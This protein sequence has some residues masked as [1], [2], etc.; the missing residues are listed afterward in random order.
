MNVIGYVRVSTEDQAENG[1]SVEGQQVALARWSVQTGHQLVRVEIDDGVSGE[2]PFA[3][4]RGGRAVMVALLSDD[5]D[6]VVAVSQ[7]RYYRDHIG[8]GM[9]HRAVTESGGLLFTVEQGDRPLCQTEG[10]QMV[11]GVAAMMHEHF[12]KSIAAHTTRVL[13]H[14][15]E[16]SL[17]SGTTPLTAMRVDDRGRP[18][19]TGNNLVPN[20]RMMTAAGLAH[21][22]QQE[23]MSLRKIG[24]R[25]KSDGYTPRDSGKDWMPTT[26]R[27]LIQQ[28]DGW[29]AL[30]PGFT[31]RK[32]RTTAGLE[33]L[34][35]AH[36]PP[37]DRAISSA[38]S[39]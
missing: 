14:R 34:L 21:T 8:W 18:S 31:A 20:P 26:V 3:A 10:E 32:R 37:R 5:V 19:P 27:S 15:R 12:R 1:Q 2:T 24:D 25:L 11:S 28:R 22:W 38:A 7:D 30:A 39:K 23:G 36:R 16:Q 17:S 13:R 35:A 29:L 9:F 4:R 33:S 6:G